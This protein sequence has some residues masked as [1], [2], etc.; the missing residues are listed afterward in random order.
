MFTRNSEKGQT[1]VFVALALVGL[2]AVAALIID[3]GSMYMQRRQAQTAADAAA[4]AGANMLCVQK[5]SI[6]EVEQTVNQ[7]AVVENRATAVESVTVVN[8]TVTVVTRITSAPFFA[9]V[10]GQESNT[11]TAQ[12]SAG[13]FN[14]ATVRNVLPIAW[15]CRPAVGGSVDAGCVLKS[16][17]WDVFKILLTVVNFNGMILDDGDGETAASYMTG[18]AG[19]G[20]LIYMVMDSDS[21]N[22]LVDC[23]ELNASGSINCDFNDDG[24]LDVEGGADRGWLLLDGGT[25][26]SDLV[27]VMLN[28]FPSP[29]TVPHWFPG[30]SG[31]A[32]S[33]FINAHQLRFKPAVIPIF[34]AVCPNTTR[35]S[36]PTACP[37]EYR[38]GDQISGTSGSSTYYRVAGFAPF[39]VTCVSKGASEPCPGKALSKVKNNMSTIEGYFISGYSVGEGI[40]PGGFDLGLYIISLTK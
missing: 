25:G 13:C 32:N 18:G 14:P 27:D 10:I 7:Y 28:G 30:K 6:A 4:L 2:F 8:Q 20:K 34:N 11:V 36:L 9:Q 24:I 38:S 12:A 33:V 29:I 19:E 40:N 15:T 16:I 17:P 1:L 37:A 26:A 5:G 3:G 31:V 23:E 35:T 39:V 21:F 22:P